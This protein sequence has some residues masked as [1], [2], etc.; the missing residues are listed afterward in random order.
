[1]PLLFEKSFEKLQGEIMSELVSSTNITRVTPGSKARAL[2]QAVNKKLN[3]AYQDFDINILQS[4]LPFAQGKFLDYIGDMVGVG[5]L[6]ATQANASLESKTVKFFVDTGTFGDINEG[7]DISLPAGSRISTG[8]NVT[9]VVYRT[10]ISTLLDAS[11]SE[12]FVAIEAVKDGET[13]NVGLNTLRYHNVTTLTGDPLKLGVT[14]ISPVTSGSSIE[15]DVNYRFRIAAQSLSAERA[16]ETA[17][18]L[19]LLT[20]PGVSNILTREYAR[21]IGTFDTVIQ[22]V[23]PNT[24]M[25]LIEACQAAIQRVAAQGVN[26]RADRPSLTGMAFQI[27]VTWRA[28]TTAADKTQIKQRILQAV[29]DYVNNLAIGEDFIVNEAIERIMAVDNRIKNIGTAHQAIDNV[30]IYRETKLRDNKIKEELL[31]DYQPE[32]D[33]RLI[34]EP[35]VEIPIIVLDKN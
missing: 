5:R 14:N 34:I 35:S 26:V 15:S 8:R 13:Q 6:G 28:E 17:I 20:V 1:M 29:S 25:A 23:V 31:A 21:G 4:F 32:P 27:S 10:V 19:A 16:N 22:S 24:P 30:F 33:E 18:R 11:L 3:R 7:L 2:L 12:Q 9:G